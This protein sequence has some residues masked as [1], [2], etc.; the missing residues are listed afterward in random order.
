MPQHFPGWYH[1]VTYPDVRTDS[2]GMM[3]YGLNPRGSCEWIAWLAKQ[4]KPAY[5]W[6]R[7]YQIV[8]TLPCS[9]S[10]DLSHSA[11]CLHWDR[12][13]VLSRQTTCQQRHSFRGLCQQCQGTTCFPLQSCL[14]VLPTPT[15][16]T[17]GIPRTL[18][19]SQ[20]WR[21]FKGLPIPSPFQQ[22][23]TLLHT[24]SIPTPCPTPPPKAAPRVPP[25]L[26]VT[27]RP[28]RILHPPIQSPVQHSLEILQAVVE[29]ERLPRHPILRV[30]SLK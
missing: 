28:L 14:R 11:K 2:L 9:H 29:I 20:F 6:S 21:C 7:G 13:V 24:P 15:S 18:T 22:S 17:F 3:A 19:T 5:M 23:P 26:K 12:V 8:I 16:D 1:F 25:P 27:R 30:K 10:E 4:S